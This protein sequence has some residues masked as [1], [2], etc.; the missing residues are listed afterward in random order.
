MYPSSQLRCHRFFLLLLLYTLGA[1]RNWSRNTVTAKRQKSFSLHRVI[2]LVPHFLQLQAAAVAI[3]FR[4]EDPKLEQKT[5]AKCRN[6]FVTLELQ[7]NA[8][9]NGVNETKWQK[10]Q[11]PDWNG[12]DKITILG[13]FQCAQL[14]LNC[15][16]L[17][18][19]GCNWFNNSDEK[20]Y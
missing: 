13:L 12:F 1:P 15:H 16:L 8:R 19:F 5:K 6:S 20:A 10:L 3:R 18:R 2:I 14:R 17:G 4:L 9:V 11:A 7:R